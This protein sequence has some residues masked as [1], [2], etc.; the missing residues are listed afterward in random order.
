MPV[1][2]C[3]DEGARFKPFPELNSG[4]VGML[5]TAYLHHLLGGKEVAKGYSG[6][7]HDYTHD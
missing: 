4:F 1:R 3:S 6:F 2:C 5:A 7:T